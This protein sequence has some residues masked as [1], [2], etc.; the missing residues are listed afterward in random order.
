MFSSTNTVSKHSSVSSDTSL[1]DDHHHASTAAPLQQKSVY[2]GLGSEASARVAVFHAYT[3]STNYFLDKYKVQRIIGFGSN[4][5]VL[6]AV[7]SKTAEAVAIKIIYKNK[8][9][10]NAQAP[11]EIEVLKHLNTPSSATNNHLL[12]YMED[13]Q[14][15]NNCYLV[16]ELFGS[17]WLSSINNSN[18]NEPEFKPITFSLQRHGITTTTVSLPVSAGS[19]DL[20]AWSYAHRA[21]MTKSE[22]HSF[23]PLAPVKQ[24]VHQIALAL[25]EM[26][27]KGFYH[28][29]LKIE[30]VLVKQSAAAK[31]GA[32]EVRLA[33][34]G[35]TK[36]AS[37]GIKAYG[38]AEVSAPEFLSDSPYASSALDGRAADVFALGMIL[39][40][41]LSGDGLVPSTVGEVM[42][43]KVGYSQLVSCNYGEYPLGDLP[44]LGE[45]AW[46]LMF[47]MTR[48][49]PG[50]RI[51]VDQVLGHAFFG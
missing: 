42:K 37:V 48:V 31:G 2:A 20:W 41:L 50:V 23:L 19:S 38:T 12:R 51:T 14:D 4:G 45:D 16:T 30:N 5:V 21:Y 7:T 46:E 17:D 9:S 26:H 28:G 24:I 11:A 10:L 43:G 47:A 18:T 34:F 44:D 36:H 29:D 25:K 49:D 32:P 22:G 33:D 3:Q 1:P 40:V 27:S 13:W 15:I 35:H 8:P 39:Y 6:A